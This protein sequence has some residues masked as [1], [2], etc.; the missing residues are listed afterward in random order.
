[1][2]TR[3]I[4]SF[5]IINLGCFIC[6][7][8]KYL[9]NGHLRKNRGH[10]EKPNAFCSSGAVFSKWS[11]VECSSALIFFGKL[12][13][14]EDGEVT[15]LTSSPAAT[16]RIIQKWR[17]LYKGPCI[18]NVRSQEG[19]GFV[20]CGHFSD[21][22]GFF[23]CG[24]PHFLVQKTSDFLK[25]MVCPHGQGGKGLS[26]CGRFADKGGG[27]QFWAD[28]FYGRPLSAL[29]KNTSKL[30]NFFTQPFL[31]FVMLSNLRFWTSHF[32]L[33]YA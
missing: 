16:N 27:G 29:P 4:Q 6:V 32:A 2:E 9:S 13:R 8:F 17:H 33:Q 19:E 22:R 14:S 31:S 30:A 20:Q 28:V 3:L 10:L 25:F 7:I 21:K 26:Q 5:Q 24:R 15:I 12:P 23:R 11:W 1:V 18:K